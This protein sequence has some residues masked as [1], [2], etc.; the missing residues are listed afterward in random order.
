[1]TYPFEKQIKQISVQSFTYEIFMAGDIQEGKRFLTAYAGNDGA[2]WSVEPTEYIYS[3]GRELGF[4]VRFINYPRFP[5]SKNEIKNEALNLAT[6]LL[7]TLGQGSCSVVGPDETY[8]LT[9][10]KEDTNG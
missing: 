7:F 9:R 3:G 8:W 10:R 1:M 4:I 5:R 2:C 6:H